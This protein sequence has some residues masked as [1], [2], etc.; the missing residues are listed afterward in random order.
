MVAKRVHDYATTSVWT[1]NTG[2]GTSTYRSYER[3]HQLSAGGKPTILGSSDP[4][5]R[6]DSQR[7]NPEELLVASLSACHMLGFLHAAAV[8]GVNVLAYLDDATGAMEE[9]AGSGVFTEVVLHPRVTVETAEMAGRCEQL[10]HQAHTACFI[11]SSV[12]FPVRHEATAEVL[13]R[14]AGDPSR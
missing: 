6:G 14:P 11:A 8:A 7:W 5:F 2:S 1:G 10:H 9:T 13:D 4:A 12:T 3:A